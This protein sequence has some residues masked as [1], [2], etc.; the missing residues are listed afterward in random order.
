MQTRKAARVL[1]EPVGAEMRVDSPARMAGQPAL[2]GLGGGAE[3]G[4]EPLGGDG[5]GP[6]EGV[7]GIDGHRA[8][9]G[10]RGF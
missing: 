8:A 9:V 6:G 5:V 2:L 3:F 7:G 4:E 10:M 1:P